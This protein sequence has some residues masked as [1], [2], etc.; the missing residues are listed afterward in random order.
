MPS[1]PTRFMIVIGSTLSALSYLVLMV[2]DVFATD[3][4]AD[5]DA[6]L[7]KGPAGV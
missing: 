2:L 3:T 1:W 7:E 5:D 6:D 4:A